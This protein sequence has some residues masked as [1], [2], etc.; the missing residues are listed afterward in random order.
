ME[1]WIQLDSS[2]PCTPTRLKNIG[3]DREDFLA[4]RAFGLDGKQFPRL[5]LAIRDAPLD[6]GRLI[7]TVSEKQ[8]V[9]TNWE[10]RGVPPELLNVV[11]ELIDE[12]SA[13]SA[14]M[15]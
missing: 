6:K 1:A 12:I 2:R 4:F 10:T 9:L 13:G 3:G 15:R 5:V 7:I 8:S 11:S 14:T